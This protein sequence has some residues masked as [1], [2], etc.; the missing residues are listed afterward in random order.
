MFPPGQEPLPGF[1]ERARR[2]LSLAQEEAQHFQHNYIGTEHLLLGLLREGQGVAAQVLESMGVSLDQAR[3]T[4]VSIIGRGDRIV[5]GEIGLTPRAKK[6]IELAGDEARRLGHHY[7][8]TEHLLLGLLR[9]GEGIAAAVLENAGINLEKGRTATIQ[10]LSQNTVSSGGPDKP[11]PTPD[12]ARLRGRDRF[13][14]FTER[15]RRVLSLAQE[16]AQHFQHNYIGTEHLLL[17]LIREDGGIAAKVL[18]SM[19]VSLDQARS[20]LEFI[21]GY[22]EHIVH[23]E[24]GLTPRAK[25]VIEFAVDEARRLGHHYIGTEHLLLGLL[26]EGEGIA[27]GILES[28]GVD[29]VRVRAAT[30]RMIETKSHLLLFPEPY[31]FNERTRQALAIAVGEATNLKHARPGPEHLLLALW[32]EEIT[33]T[34]SILNSLNIDLVRAR[35]EVEKLA[36]GK[37]TPSQGPG[38]PTRLAIAHIYLAANE[39]EQRGQQEIAPEHLLLSLLSLEYG[40]VNTLL[41]RLGID[42]EALRRRIYDSLQDKP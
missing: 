26:R 12:T 41:T 37:A 25:R 4:I 17:A 13:D 2:V 20:T 31:P 32:H 40:A 42:K 3:T 39:A 34:S 14:K 18:N 33:N 6:A 38:S 23:G 8:G 22:G 7:I 21:I 29:P 1:T 35:A 16:E 36:V 9:E 30:Y 19:N 28:L 24:I 27:S 5:L 10:L 15:A 11:S